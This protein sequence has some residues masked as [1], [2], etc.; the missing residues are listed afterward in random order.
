[1]RL[2]NSNIKMYLTALHGTGCPSFWVIRQWYL[3]LSPRFV[4]FSEGILTGRGKRLAATWARI[5]RW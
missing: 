3:G 2:G 4:L 1:M 5:K